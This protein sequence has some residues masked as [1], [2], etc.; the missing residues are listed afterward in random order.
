[1]GYNPLWFDRYL[2]MMVKGVFQSNGILK[3]FSFQTRQDDLTTAFRCR[4]LSGLRS[5][6]SEIGPSEGRDTRPASR[7]ASSLS[8]GNLYFHFC[9]ASLMFTCLLFIDLEST[10]NEYNRPEYHCFN[11][12]DFLF[13]KILFLL[14][15]FPFLIFFSLFSFHFCF[16]L[17]LSWG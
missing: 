12:T 6:Y 17:R 5:V 13:F 3:E 15:F 1:M 7:G 9:V 4:T 14:Y 16:P 10:N 11:T 8:R 2:M